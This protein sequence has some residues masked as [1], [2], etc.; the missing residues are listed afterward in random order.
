MLELVDARE[1]HIRVRIVHHA[2]PLTVR[3]RHAL[4]LEAERTPGERSVLVA[5]ER[6]DGTRVEYGNVQLVRLAPFEP[7]HIAFKRD[8]RVVEETVE[9]RVVA[10]Q[11]NALSIVGKVV[12]VVA[13]AHGQALDDRRGQVLRVHAPLL[14][15]VLADEGAIER[16][17]DKGNGL[18]LEVCR[19]TRRVPR[20]LR[21]EGGQ[22]GRREV[23]AVELVDERKPERKEVRLPRMARED[24]VLVAVERDEAVHERPHVVEVR[25]EDVRAVGVDLDAGFGVSL[26]PHVPARCRATFEHEYL[27]PFFGQHAR[28]RAPPN[29]CTSHYDVDFLHC[30]LSVLV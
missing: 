17:A 29:A 13:R 12:D 18:L 5:E 11:R 27:A 14:A 6:V 20:L 19:F 28:N 4:R 22:F 7:V 9:E 15:R 24:L 2:R 23:E 1:G 26:A 21:D 3:N 16:F 25:V 30:H 8:V 10:R